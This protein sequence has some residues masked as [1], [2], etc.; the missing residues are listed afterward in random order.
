MKKLLIWLKNALL[1]FA[2]KRK[3]KKHEMQVIILG[4]I[5]ANDEIKYYVRRGNVYY[6]VTGDYD[7]TKEKSTDYVTAETMVNY[8]K[9]VQPSE[10]IPPKK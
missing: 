7:I 9:I 6:P 3:A 10:S 8:F 5:L 4:D 2:E 1:R